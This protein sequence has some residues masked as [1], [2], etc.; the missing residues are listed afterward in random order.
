MLNYSTYPV[1]KSNRIQHVVTS[2]GGYKI[3]T[4]ESF[5]S[6]EYAQLADTGYIDLTMTVPAGYRCSFTYQ[7]DT[8][9]SAGLEVFADSVVSGGTTRLARNR[10]EEST[11]TDTVSLTVG[12]TITD[13]GTTLA[14]WSWGSAAQPV[15]GPNTGGS[16]S[17]EKIVWP[18]NTV[19]RFRLTSNAASNNCTI[20][21]NF[22]ME[23]MIPEEL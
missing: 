20:R 4:G 3:N 19:R 13:P 10:N 14:A 8:A 21:V 17:D 15:A 7:I 22:V 12:G 5:T 16:D 2:Y 9:L 11:N 1:E 18:E 23:K 6:L